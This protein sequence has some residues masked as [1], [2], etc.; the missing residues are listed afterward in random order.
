MNFKVCLNAPQILSR[1]EF[2]PS[3]SCATSRPRHPVG[4]NDRETGRPVLLFRSDRPRDREEQR[5]ME[6]TLSEAAELIGIPQKRLYR[7]VKA[8]KLN[9]TQRHQGSRWEYLVSQDDLEDFGRSTARPVYQDGQPVATDQETGRAVEG[10]TDRPTDQPGLQPP[11]EVY[12][13]LIDRLSRAE[14]RSVELELQLRQ[15]QRLLTENAESITEKEALAQQARAQVEALAKG[16]EEEVKSLR[17]ELEEARLQLEE[18]QKP[19]G[20]FSWLGLRKKRTTSVSTEK[21]V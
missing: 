6:M 18:A 2:M 19:K 16:K 1:H 12:I 10:A 9:A 8:G 14:R 13:A 7:A 4:R 5:V 3:L 20:F 11:A 17:A 15:S 21:A